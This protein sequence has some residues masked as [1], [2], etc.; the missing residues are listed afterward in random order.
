MNWGKQRNTLLPDYLVCEY[1]YIGVSEIKEPKVKLLFGK[2]KNHEK[3]FIISVIAQ[4]SISPIQFIPET[5]MVL[6]NFVEMLGISLDNVD[7]YLDYNEVSKSND[8]IC[9]FSFSFEPK[10]SIDI[11]YGED[12]P[13][14]R[15]PKALYELY[16]KYLG[17]DKIDGSIL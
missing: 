9:R 6:N 14:S 4:D 7:C 11:K 5:Y 15:L 8:K 1:T 3:P 16:E 2:A 17:K 12:I 10:G 13:F